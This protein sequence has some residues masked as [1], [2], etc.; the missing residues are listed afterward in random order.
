MSAVDSDK[1]NSMT[2]RRVL[3]ALLLL[4][5]G[6]ETLAC[7]SHRWHSLR[8]ADVPE[9]ALTEASHQQNAAARRISDLGI[10]NQTSQLCGNAPPPDELKVQ[11][12]VA[13]RDWQ[14]KNNETHRN[15]EKNYME[16]NRLEYKKGTSL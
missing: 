1:N 13:F 3:C 5:F 10:N 2:R 11:L 6:H 14:Q 9:H 12:G 7:S 4:F 8:G 16:Y 15:L